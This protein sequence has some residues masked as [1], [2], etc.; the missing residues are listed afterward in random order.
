MYNDTM[1]IANQVIQEHLNVVTGVIR[2]RLLDINHGNVQSLKIIQDL[3]SYPHAHLFPSYKQFCSYAFDNP[4]KIGGRLI[5]SLPPEPA[6]AIAALG[7]TIADRSLAPN[8][9]SNKVGWAGNV[10]ANVD[11]LLLCHNRLS[12]LELN[13]LIEPLHWQQF[14]LKT[15][16]LSHN[17]LSCASMQNLMYAITNVPLPSKAVHSIVFLNLANNNIDDV[18]AK[19]ISDALVGEQLTATRVI[20]VSGNKITEVG[21]KCFSMA[22]KSEAVNFIAIT[23]ESHA[24]RDAVV[25]FLKKG[26][27]Y[28][29]KEFVKRFKNNIDTQYIKTDEDSAFMHCK[30]GVPKAVVGVTLGIAKCTNPIAKIINSLPQPGEKVPFVTKAVNKLGLFACVMSEE[31]DNIVTPDLVGCV[32]EVN[33]YLGFGHDDF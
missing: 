23:L 4:E 27:S 2:G 14:K 16:D 3:S 15:L 20:D 26:S 24:G 6:K 33:A 17:Y 18:G 5:I 7:K 10:L 13:P 25:D 11:E 22:L 8:I 1:D 21:Q 12:D 19:I 9:A 31:G 30:E 29:F 28:Y 32:T